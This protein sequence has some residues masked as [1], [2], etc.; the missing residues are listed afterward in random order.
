MERRME[1][2]GDRETEQEDDFNR[3]RAELERAFIDYEM[4]SEEA[5]AKRRKRRERMRDSS[6]SS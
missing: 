2:T 5:R 4:T 1:D 3:P 6:G